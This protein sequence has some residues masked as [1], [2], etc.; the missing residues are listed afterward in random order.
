[1]ASTHLAKLVIFLIGLLILLV[2][3]TLVITTKPETAELL[4]GRDWSEV[5]RKISRLNL[6]SKVIEQYVE[7]KTKSLFVR[8]KNIWC[9]VYSFT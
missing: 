4:D 3:L 9:K 6:S 1:M 7:E 5:R 2:I 8:V